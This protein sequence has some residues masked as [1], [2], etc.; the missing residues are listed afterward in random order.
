MPVPDRQPSVILSVDV[1]GP[2]LHLALSGE[3]DLACAEEFDGLFDLG[4]EG[5]D[6]I[7]L[8]LDQ[9]SFCDVTGVNAL[10]GFQSFHQAHGREVRLVGVRPQLRRL[11]TWTEQAAARPRAARA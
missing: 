3:L 8:D 1:V 4:T 9:L 10:T 2:V 7:V 5:I 6:R 11:L